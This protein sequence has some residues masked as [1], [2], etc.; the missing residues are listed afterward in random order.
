VTRLD[1][2]DSLWNVTTPARCVCPPGAVPGD[3]LVGM[4]LGDLGVELALDP[5]D[6]DLPVGVGLVELADGLDLV[7]FELVNAPTL[8]HLQPDMTALEWRVRVS[9]DGPPLLRQLRLAA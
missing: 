9:T 7:V 5:A 8:A 4:L 1:V 3:A 2:S 6:L